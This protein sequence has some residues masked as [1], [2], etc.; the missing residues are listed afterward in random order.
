MRK[1]AFES[2]VL[3]RDESEGDILPFNQQKLRKM[4]IVRAKPFFF[5]N[6]TALKPDYFD[7]A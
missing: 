1:V 2:I 4:A 3:L 5:L 7:T 6:S